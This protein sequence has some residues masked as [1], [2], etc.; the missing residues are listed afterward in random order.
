MP[1][2]L[3]EKL[4]GMYQSRSSLITTFL[5]NVSIHPFKFVDLSVTGYTPAVSLGN[6]NVEIRESSFP[7]TGNLPKVYSDDFNG[8]GVDISWKVIVVYFMV[9]GS[10][11]ILKS[12]TN[13]GGSIKCTF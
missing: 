1:S 7:S 13:F 11:L 10:G 6:V 2:S 5:V 4:F 9:V 8:P 12:A 3:G